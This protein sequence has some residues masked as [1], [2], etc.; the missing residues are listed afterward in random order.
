MFQQR[1]RDHVLDPAVKGPEFGHG[2]AAAS[3]RRRSRM[4]SWEEE[5]DNEV[6]EEEEDE[7]EERPKLTVHCHL[8]GWEMSDKRIPKVWM[9]AMPRA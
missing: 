9:E 3:S 8:M 2:D 1:L 5:E 7:G 4:V 6:L